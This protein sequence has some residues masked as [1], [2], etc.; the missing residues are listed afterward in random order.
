MK[1]HS[2]STSFMQILSPLLFEPG[3]KKE[4]EK[5]KDGR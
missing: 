2:I 5:G 1:S 3:K 4:E